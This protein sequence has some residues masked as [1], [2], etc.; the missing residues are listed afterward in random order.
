MTAEQEESPEESPEVTK[1][2]PASESVT[3]PLS[4]IKGKTTIKMELPGGAK[5]SI[6]IEGE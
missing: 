1:I 6:I 3:L 5:L 4:Q 2:E